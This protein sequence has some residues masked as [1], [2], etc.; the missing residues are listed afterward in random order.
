MQRILIARCN[1]WPELSASDRLYADAL[2][3]RGSEVDA[4]PWN[5][6]PEPFRSADVVVLRSTWDYHYELDR[7]ATWLDDLER[8]G[9]PVYN[10]PDLVRWNLTG[11]F[12]VNSQYGARLEPAS[13]AESVVRQA[14]AVLDALPVMPLY[15]RVDGLPRA[16]GFMLMELEL[17]EPG[18]ALELAEGAADRFAEATIRRP[19]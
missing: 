10:S 14:R 5:G 3:A 15:A 17:I 13:P 18:L 12:R 19:P 11:E 16:D 4:A 9:V 7:F 8:R 2:I 6:P 1:R